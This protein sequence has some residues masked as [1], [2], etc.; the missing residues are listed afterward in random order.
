MDD[1][2]SMK[3]QTRAVFGALAAL[4]LGLAAVGGWTQ[5][6]AHQESQARLDRIVDALL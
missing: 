5:Y 2:S 1:Q 6:Q 3:N 4:L